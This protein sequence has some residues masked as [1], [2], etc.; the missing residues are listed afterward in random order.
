MECRA[1]S[2]WALLASRET[3]LATTWHIL[4][5]A[6]KLMNPLIT[7]IQWQKNL[8]SI[9]SQA[10]KQRLRWAEE[11]GQSCGRTWVWTKEVC[12]K[13]RGLNECHAAL[14]SESHLRHSGSDGKESACNAGEPGL[15]SGSGRSPG[16]GNGNPSSILAWR[17]PWT[18]EPGRLQSTG[19]PRVRHDWETN[20][21]A[22]T[23]RHSRFFHSGSCP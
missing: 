14:W 10:T 15:I 17:I 1:L 3:L 4:S 7:S 8:T 23:F 9:I 12:S 13:A 21:L 16:E 19:L 5:V 22:S 2:L 18:E 20:T 6:H 11:P